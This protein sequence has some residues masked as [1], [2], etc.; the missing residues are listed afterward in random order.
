VR[1]SSSI[2]TRKGNVPQRLVLAE[3]HIG[4]L[5][6]AGETCA[7]EAAEN[8]RSASDSGQQ[9]HEKMRVSAR[10]EKMRLIHLVAAMSM[11]CGQ[12]GAGSGWDGPGSGSD[13]GSGDI[14]VQYG[15]GGD[16]F[17][18]PPQLPSP[19][20][21]PPPPPAAPPPLP[22]PPLP[23]LRLGEQVVVEHKVEIRLTAAGNVADYDAARRDAIRQPFADAANIPFSS[24]DVTVVDASVEITVEISTPDA[25]TSS[26]V[27][28]ALSTQMAN[29][30]AASAFLAA[31]SVAVVS[32][33]VVAT[34]THTRVVP[35]PTP[36]PPSPPPPGGTAPPPPPGAEANAIGVVVGLLGSVIA[37]GVGVACCALLRP[38][39]F[40]PLRDA[41]GDAARVLSK[42]TKPPQPHVV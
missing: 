7:T 41:K 33:P 16:P 6:H 35:V 37:L 25:S 28:A 24:V 8:S 31:A 10:P 3:P 27:S 2:L 34:T 21:P 42:R 5:Q 22:P 32:A 11:V 15:S 36:P 29:A 38:R 20:E 30:S 18:P 9:D 1:R 14:V 17:T 23:P 40:F 12:K 39:F 26:A 13:D 4:L 19:A